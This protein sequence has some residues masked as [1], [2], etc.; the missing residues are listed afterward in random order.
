MLPWTDRVRFFRWLLLWTRQV[1]VDELSFLDGCQSGAEDAREARGEDQDDALDA[2][3]VTEPVEEVVDFSILKICLWVHSY[4][5]EGKQIFSINCQVI[6]VDFEIRLLVKGQK[7]AYNFLFKKV[8]PLVFTSESVLFKSEYFLNET[9]IFR[10]ECI[11]DWKENV[12][13]LRLFMIIIIDHNLSTVDHEDVER[14]IL[15]NFIFRLTNR[16]SVTLLDTNLIYGRL[17]WI[18]GGV[19]IGF[20]F[21]FFVDTGT[22]QH[23]TFFTVW[24][25]VVVRIT[26]A[27]YKLEFFF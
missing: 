23:I 17:D 26:S 5:Y 19:K 3:N 14:E 27:G 12:D 4:V 15:L 9:A 18:W 11:N 2:A 13:L 6:W 20:L 25:K 7:R 16:L 10:D 8:V 22:G 24:H 1:L 21:V